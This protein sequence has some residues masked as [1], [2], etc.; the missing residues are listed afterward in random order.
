MGSAQ[1]DSTLSQV[2][3]AFAETGLTID[4]AQPRIRVANSE[5]TQNRLS[6]V[7]IGEAPPG[8]VEIVENRIHHNGANGISA[9]A[10]A[11]AWSGGHVAPLIRANDIYRNAVGIYL[12]AVSSSGSG[13]LGVFCPSA[14]T[15]GDVGSNHIHLN[16]WGISTY[17]ERYGPVDTWVGRLPTA[18]AGL[19]SLIHNNIVVG[20][21][22]PGISLATAGDGGPGLSAKVI[23]NTLAG[24]RGAGIWHSPDVSE[25]F[26]IQ[27][28][29][30]YKNLKGIVSDGAFDPAKIS[31]CVISYNDNADNNKNDWVN[32]PATYGKRNTKNAQGLP[33]DAAMNL[34]WDPLFYKIGSWNTN[35]T[36]KDPNDDFWTNGDYHLKSHTGRWD[37]A[38]NRWVKDTMTSVCVDAGDPKTPVGDEPEPNGGRI[39]MGAYGGT[40]QSSK[41]P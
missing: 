27:N 17:S 9:S 12:E 3:I 23:N 1:Q 29:I 14:T 39:D 16:G 24:N 30:V 20:N 2:I 8:S 21:F 13:C 38:N 10:S 28:N 4:G 34:S 33:L 35:G 32:Y 36:S 40:A 19:G 22:G 11:D 7:A 37:P 15:S 18:G 25:G 41:S 6:G 31:N 26:A 5:I